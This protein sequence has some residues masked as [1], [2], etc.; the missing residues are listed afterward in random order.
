MFAYDGHKF[1]IVLHNYIEGGIRLD[2]E[3][4]DDDFQTWFPYSRITTCIPRITL[5]PDEILINT[6]DEFILDFIAETGLAY[7]REKVVASGYNLYEVYKLN[8]EL[9]Q[10]ELNND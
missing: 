3:E 6:D 7:P 10:K 2:L 9:I 4:W 8:M 5:S 1:K